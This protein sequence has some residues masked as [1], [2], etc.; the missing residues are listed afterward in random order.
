MTVLPLWDRRSPKNVT[1][2]PPSGGL[3]NS[4]RGATIVPDV[5]ET[6]MAQANRITRFGADVDL[7]SRRLQQ[8]LA[9]ATPWLMLRPNVE[10]IHHPGGTGERR[11]IVVLGLKAFL[12]F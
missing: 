7:V 10:Y 2:S 6:L 11:S 5:S 3:R 1:P 8:F 9:H 4:G 12:T